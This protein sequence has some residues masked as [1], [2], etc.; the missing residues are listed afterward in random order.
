MLLT[1]LML[2]HSIDTI[3]D[4]FQQSIAHL[5]CAGRDGCAKRKRE[6]SELEANK[7][8]SPVAAWISQART[9][10]PSAQQHAAVSLQ[11]QSGDVLP[12]R[13]FSVVPKL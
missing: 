6:D 9:A 13:R 4:T 12:L 5:S 3:F 7:M 2:V 8:Q 11:D 1:K 10:A